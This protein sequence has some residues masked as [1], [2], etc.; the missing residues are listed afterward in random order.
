MRCDAGSRWGKET[1]LCDAEAE[2]VEEVEVCVREGRPGWRAGGADTGI[3]AEEG[4]REEVEREGEG[5]GEVLLVATI[6]CGCG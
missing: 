5:E 2:G 6:G 4:A 1:C 3:D